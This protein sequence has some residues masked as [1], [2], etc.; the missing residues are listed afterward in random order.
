[1]ATRAGQGRMRPAM[2]AAVVLAA[3][4]IFPSAL[5][6]QEEPPP[7][8]AAAEIGATPPA[9]AAG[10]SAAKATDTV[11]IRNFKVRPK[12]VTID[13]G[14]RVRWRNDD[15]DDHTPPARDGSFD[16][17]PPTADARAAEQYGAARTARST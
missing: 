12:P 17:G 7:G 15:A 3:V 8:D 9:R 6:A 10:G 2:A 11:E 1:M 4:A 5:E 14:D 13:V 16:T